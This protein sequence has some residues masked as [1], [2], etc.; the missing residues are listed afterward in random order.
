MHKLAL[1]LIGG[2]VLIYLQSLLVM[3]WNGYT[4]IV[5]Q[6]ISMLFTLW[7]V[8]VFIVFSV[9]AGFQG[10]PGKPNHRPSA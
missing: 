10:S 5:F 6:D 9:L 8:N 7:A 1:S 2:F 4:S 3:K